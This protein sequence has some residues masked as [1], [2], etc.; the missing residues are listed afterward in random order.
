MRRNKRAAH[1]YPWLYNPQASV[2]QLQKIINYSTTTALQY[3]SSSGLTHS[4]LIIQRLR[5]CSRSRLTHSKLITQWLQHYSSSRLRLR[6]HEHSFISIQFY[7]FEIAS[8]SMR[9]GSVYREPVSYSLSHAEVITDQRDQGTKKESTILFFPAWQ[10]VHR[11]IS[12]HLDWRR[13]RTPFESNHWIQ[14]L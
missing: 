8:K 2:N 13:G 4:K 5:H 11:Y 10:K 12:V 7:D 6:V 9:F 1:E 14:S 3:C